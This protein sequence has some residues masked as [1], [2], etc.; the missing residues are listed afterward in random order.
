M[1]N[2]QHALIQERLRSAQLCRVGIDQSIPLRPDPTRAPLSYSQ[3]HIWHYERAH[4]F[5]VSNNLG[6]LFTFKGT[7]D[8]EAVAY[9]FRSV[10]AR[11]EILRTTYHQN[12]DGAPFQYIHA[13]LPPRI[14]IERTTKEEAVKAAQVELEK[15]FNLAEDS[16]IRLMISRTGV[17]EVIVAMIAHHIVWDGATFPILVSDFEEAYAAPDVAL[18]EL[19][20]QYGD[21]AHWQ[22]A[23]LKTMLEEHLEY[24][25]EKLIQ[26]RH[27]RA[28][29]AFN[30][31]GATQEGAGR[32]DRRLASST[33]L[34]NLARRHTVT[35]FIAFLA[36]WIKVLGRLT[37]AV[38]LGTTAL[39]RDEPGTSQLIG[40]LAN[41]LVLQIDIAE[42]QTFSELAAATAA[43]FE[44]VYDHRQVPY[45]TIAENIVGQ[46]P[47]TPPQ[48]FDSLVVFIPGGTNG[49]QVPGAQTY[50]RRLHNGST[51]FPLVPLGL[52]VFVRGDDARA[53]IDVEA[54]F[55]Y[56]VL[57]VGKTSA[58]LEELDNA[59]RDAE[60]G[61][62]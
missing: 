33:Q 53:T 32:V 44:S 18:P 47:I 28:L 55:A 3:S 17:E 22:Q 52:E 4:P 27:P 12:D 60:E 19:S 38:S 59:I 57:D 37:P 40:N 43:E 11:H 2:S 9:A 51:Q 8:E 5:S 29:A 26:H 24:W 48:L 25:E 41:Y 31:P 23:N 21:V 49:P 14:Q 45:A 6:I 36:C 7:V 39:T 42:H 46:T 35:P 54:T 30:A 1:S 58:L 20:I 62:W 50:W 10:V 61:T 16:P 34:K 13:E 56:D 15:P